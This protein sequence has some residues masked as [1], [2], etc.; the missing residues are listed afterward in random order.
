MSL[1]DYSTGYG[2]HTHPENAANLKEAGARDDSIEYNRDWYGGLRSVAHAGELLTSGWQEG[3]ARLASIASDLAPPTAKS[4]KR[5]ARWEAEGDDLHVERALRGDW[6][7]A[8]RTTRRQWSPGPAT[9]TLFTPVGGASYLTSEHLFWRGAVA[10][11]VADLLESAGYSVEIVA[12]WLVRDCERGK[13]RLCRASVTLKDPG[14]PL[15]IDALASVLCH[16]GVIRSYGFGMIA[17]IPH[18]V[19]PA[20]GFNATAGGDWE[21][22]AAA[23]EIPEGS[24]VIAPVTDESGCKAEI[25]RILATLA[26]A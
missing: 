17:A 14:Q 15:A 20:M 2:L 7:N 18:N 4:R 19:G 12:S 6:D 25:A 3:A 22:L 1:A 13:G 5:V 21:K 26:P 9:V 23:G 11:V 24:L 16:A 8:W 10:L